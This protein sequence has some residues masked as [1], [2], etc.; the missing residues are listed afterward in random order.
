VPAD[1][2][3]LMQKFPSILHTRDVKPTLTHGVVYHI[4]TGSHPP[5]I[6]KSRRFD[7]EK[8]QNSQG[9]V[10]KVRICWHCSQVKITMGFPFAHGTQKRWF[11]A[12][13]WRLSPF[14]FSDNP[15]QVS[16]TKHAGPFQWPAWLHSLLKNRSC[17][18]LSPNPSCDR[19][20]P[21]N[22]IHNT[23]CLDRIFFHPFWAVQRHTDFSKNDG[24]HHR[25]SGRCVCIHG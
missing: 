11:V 16:Y 4:H 5:V 9:R 2:K 8:P 18:G 7:S 12:T 23:I 25:W 1:V 10:Q 6:A 17:H 19:G 3:T 21:K 20:H 14:K 13:F 22:C 24:L 15:G